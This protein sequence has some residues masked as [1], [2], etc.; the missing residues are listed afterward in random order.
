MTKPN[1]AKFAN[2]IRSGVVKHSPELLIGIGISGMI[3]ASVLTAKATPKALARIEQQ[4]RDN[5]CAPEDLRPLEKVKACWKCYIP[6]AV[7]AT[8]SATCIIGANSVNARRNAALAAA[9][10]LSDTAFR[11][12]RKKTLETLGEK[13][14]QI[15]RD[16]VAEDRVHKKPVERSEVFLTDKGNTLCF[17]SISARYFKSDIELIK[18]SVNELNRVMLRDSY[19]SLN[20]FYDELGL[21]HTAIGDDLGWK[22]DD[23]LVEI[24]FSSQLATDGTPCLVMDYSIT[25][26]YDFYKF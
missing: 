12:F 25:P 3:F 24:N 7:V 8:T 23:G 15:I 2:D 11:E 18:R 17:D 6:A 13:K 14:E 4:A 9:Y 5:N 21:E 16:K 19:V 10:T 1:V 26:K 22:V 20:D